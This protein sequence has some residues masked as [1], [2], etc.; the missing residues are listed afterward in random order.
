MFTLDCWSHTHRFTRTGPHFP[1]TV[2]VPARFDFIG[3]WTDTPPYFFDHPSGVLNSTLS[4]SHSI[5]RTNCPDGSN[6]SIE[7][8][9]RHSERCTITENGLPVPDVSRHIVLARTFE[10]LGM[11]SPALSIDIRNSIPHGSGLG[12]SSLLTASLLCALNAYHRGAGVLMDHLDEVVNNVLYIEQMMDSGGGWQDQIGGLYP[13][14]KL[15]AA[16]PGAPCSYTIGYI[17][18]GIDLLGACSLVIDSG[19]RRKAA[20]I[21]VSIRGKYVEGDPRTAETLATIAGNACLGFAHLEN[22][23]IPSFAGLLSNSWRM[24]NDIESGSV[25]MVEKLRSLCGNDLMGIKI[26]GAGGGGFILAIFSDPGSRDFHS[27]RISLE[28]PGCTVYEPVFGI[29]GLIVSE[30]RGTG[31]RLYRAE[32][33]ELLRCSAHD[34]PTRIP[35]DVP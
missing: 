20:R 9:I 1:V 2:R 8:S 7:I 4:L 35:E 10:F 17:E 5:G 27:R 30:G 16:I 13:G 18:R 23:D 3:G 12:G 33:T 22:L 26:G 11:S 34:S 31:V 25:D 19:I 14:V 24:V 15:I 28:F 32:R 29:D 6:A 21:L